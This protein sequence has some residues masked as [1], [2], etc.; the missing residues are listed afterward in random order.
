M[1]NES[2]EWVVEALWSDNDQVDSHSDVVLT[3]SRK[4]K[5]M[6]RCDG[7]SPRNGPILIYDDQVIAL[8]RIIQ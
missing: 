6:P 8:K 3:I 5:P 1:A 7:V 4:M 2:T